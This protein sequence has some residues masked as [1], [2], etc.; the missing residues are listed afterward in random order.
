[1]IY[2]AMCPY[3]VSEK[4]GLKKDASGSTLIQRAGLLG[5]QVSVQ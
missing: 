5:V 2:N 4:K 1:M 3:D